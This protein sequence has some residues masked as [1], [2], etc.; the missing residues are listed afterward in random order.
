MHAV[1]SATANEDVTENGIFRA[2][3]LHDRVSSISPVAQ[4]STSFFLTICYVLAPLALSQTNT[5][6]DGIGWQCRG[7][8]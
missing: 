6:F 1:N 4:A 2:L 3:G 5:C 7:L 8:G